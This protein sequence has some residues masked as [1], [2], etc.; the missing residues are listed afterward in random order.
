MQELLEH[1][2]RIE[3]RDWLAGE[4]RRTRGR[5]ALGPSFFLSAS[6]VGQETVCGTL[7]FA[8]GSKRRREHH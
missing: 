8:E 1:K 5:A 4:R 6:A 2:H 3:S 7:G